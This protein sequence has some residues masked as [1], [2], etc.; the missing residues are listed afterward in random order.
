MNTMLAKRATLGGD[1]QSG[2]EQ[3]LASMGYTMVKDRAPRLLDHMLGFQILDRN[4]DNTKAAAVFG[5]EV[6][7][8]VLYVPIFFINNEIKGHE[9][10]YLKKQDEF[11]PLKENWVNYILSRKPYAIGEPS[12][13]DTFQRG[14]VMPDMRMLSGDRSQYKYGSD[15]LDGNDPRNPQEWAKGFLPVYA[16]MRTGQ[17]AKLAKYAKLPSF[18]DMMATSWAWLKTACDTFNSYPTLFPAFQKVYGED[19]LFQAAQKLQKKLAA[20]MAAVQPTQK[21][22]RDIL[23][24]LQAE[25]HPIHTG[26][27]LIE[28]RSGRDQ[29][30]SCLVPS[31]DRSADALYIVDKRAAD[32]KSEIF[33]ASGGVT[34][35]NPGQTGIYNMLSKPGGDFKKCLVIRAPFSGTER[36]DHASL[37]IELDGKKSILLD[38]SSAWVDGSESQDSYRT[39]FDGLS[40]S[41]SLTTDGTYV[42]LTPSGDGTVAF[43]VD[44]KV[45][46]SRYT[47]RYIGCPVRGRNRLLKADKS[48]QYSPNMSSETNSTDFCGRTVLH[49][50][51]RPGTKFKVVGGELFVP[52]DAKFFKVKDRWSDIWEDDA[53]LQPGTQADLHMKIA[54]STERLKVSFNG[55]EVILSSPYH[56]KQR[57]SKLAAIVSLVKDHGITELQAREV[58]K[59]SAT[60]GTVVFH[61]RYNPLYK[62]ADHPGMLTNQGPTAPWSPQ[63]MFGTEMLY[64]GPPSTYPQ[65]EQLPIP[66]LD[67]SNTDPWIY[68]PTRPIEPDSAQSLQQ[69]ANTGDKDILDASA[70]QNMLKSVGQDSLVDGFLGDLVKA[71]DRL[72]RLLFNFYWHA[73][74]LSE[75]YGAASLK[76]LRDAIR[77][78][79]EGLGD[80]VL[81]LR[82]NAANENI[83]NL[84]ETSVSDVANN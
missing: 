22:S 58:L 75:R 1:P 47:V 52:S 69:A 68:D 29:D 53:P 3:A 84:S 37:V 71:L 59:Q 20:E 78:E 76:E 27:L 67:G 82:T 77:N 2:L 15:H 12:R 4:D 57:F 50:S 41:D 43:D 80:V 51:R 61:M 45:G 70:L 39:W 33:E 79:F 18:P 26:N 30:E 63:Q 66:E 54:A 64:G 9:L 16:Q 23:W 72:G 31:L 10:L 49:L 14:G 65:E 8:Q 62:K 38:P 56:G 73:D 5:F 60:K 42:A 19:F 55:G 81:E 83:L 6:D 44:S 40:S 36:K 48:Y 35:T 74:D 25:R 11:V 46:E 21:L 17:F 13:K 24:E 7:K 34:L 28:Y 32:E